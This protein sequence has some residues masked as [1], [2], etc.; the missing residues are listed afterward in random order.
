MQAP[1][2]PAAPMNHSDHSADCGEQRF[3][4][5]LQIVSQ[6]WPSFPPER[7]SVLGVSDLPR[8]RS[9]RR[10]AKLV[11]AVAVAVAS[12][13][14]GLLVQGTSAKATKKPSILRAPASSLRWT[15][16]RDGLGFECST[17]DV[18]LDYTNPKGRKI[19]VALSR[20]PARKPDK[21]IG[22]MLVNPGGPGASGKKFARQLA[23][24]ALPNEIR[25]RFDLIGFDPRGVADTMPIK[26]VTGKE[27]DRINSVDPIPDSPEEFAQLVAA[28]K[29][30]AEGCAR[31]NGDNLK[32]TAT[33]DVVRD[34]DVIR[35]ALGV[36]QI[37]YMG[38]SYGTFL[39]AKYADM[40]PKRVRAFLLDGALD[41]TVD[42]DER[43]RRQGVGFD[44]EL[45]EFFAA[46]DRLTNCPF[47]KPDEKADAAFDRILSGIDAKALKTG[48]RM[49][50]PGE[51]WT[52]VLTGLYNKEQGWPILRSALS[53]ANKGD[54]SGLLAMFDQY[55]NR[56]PDG[57]YDNVVDANAATN[58]LDVPASKSID[59]YSALA[60]EFE[61]LAPRFGR[62]AALS[63]MIC[64]FWKIP[65]RGA[66]TP[67]K[68]TGAAP[69]LV[70]GTTRDPATPYV[71][72][73]SLSKQLSGSVLLTYDGDGHTAFLTR[74][75]CIREVVTPY[76]VDLKVPQPGVVC[77]S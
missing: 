43:V 35:E 48:D 55:A 64:A 53:N 21:K 14:A 19:A 36:E 59:H 58:C 69:I 45:N 5:V 74:N 61:K 60:D 22:V 30:F 23:F 1:G 49:L 42:S 68:A 6:R 46:C 54:G 72:A 77:T 24:G 70:V 37:S 39:G 7:I 17:V 27:F 15:S 28:N 18:P 71:W 3:E 34:M 75:A 9:G 33:A 11:L 65:V 51:A 76:L 73:Q 25:D 47:A 38:F 26:C 41:P 13:G 44:S 67:V 20:V 56:N 32:F 50:G 12:V 4:S 31:R 16:C 57:S 40:F 10:R 52:G 2:T 66:L 63:S 8:I 62:F 29:E